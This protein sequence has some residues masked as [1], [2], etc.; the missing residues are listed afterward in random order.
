MP[1][2]SSSIRSCTSSPGDLWNTLLCGVCSSFLNFYSSKNGYVFD[3]LSQLTGQKCSE[4]A[5]RCKCNVIQYVKKA[6]VLHICKSLGHVQ[7]YTVNNLEV[8]IRKFP[9]VVL[10]ADL[11][12]APDL[13]ATLTFISG[14]R[15]CLDSFITKA[16]ESLTWSHG[17]ER[18]E[19]ALDF[20]D[21][22]WLILCG[23]W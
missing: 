19:S 6:Q 21:V 17:F 3:Q 14:H 13:P 4:L 9:L 8:N 22:H 1:Y 12:S 10:G 11:P 2:R 18:A 23:T 5:E 7:Y 16:T 15:F 20:V